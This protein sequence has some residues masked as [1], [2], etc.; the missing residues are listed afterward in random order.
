MTKLTSLRPRTVP[1][2]LGLAVAACGWPVAGMAQVVAPAARDADTVR[3]SDEQRNAI[4][5]GNTMESA[6]AARGEL[7]GAERA[8]RGVH[9]EVGVMI[10]TNG[11]RG[12]YGVAAIPLGEHGEAVVSFENSQYGGR[13]R[14]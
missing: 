9:G 3:L 2:M 8:A 5:A 7:S 1:I 6:A 4:L 12:I 13:R 14:R 10:G 11:A